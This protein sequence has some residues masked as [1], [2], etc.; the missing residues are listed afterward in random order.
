MKRKH[1][2]P[3]VLVLALLVTLLG[4]CA[5]PVGQQPIKIVSVTG[6]LSPANPGGPAVEITLKNVSAEPVVS[7]TA[8]LQLSLAFGFTFNI[9]SSQPL[10]PGRSVSAKRTLIGSGFASG[11]PYTLAI[12]GATQGGT[13][14]E[15]NKQVKVVKP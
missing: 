8:T 12:T 4:A 15:Y 10:L 1:L 5:G 2:L 14:F 6:P 7:L 9:S 13:A 3:G 11:T